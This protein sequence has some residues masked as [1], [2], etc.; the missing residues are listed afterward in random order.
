LS[1]IFFLKLTLFHKYKYYFNTMIFMQNIH[2]KLKHTL[3]DCNDVLQNCTVNT[4]NCTYNIIV[5][6]II[7]RI[8]LQVY[9][10]IQQQMR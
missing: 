2:T 5:I 9:I 4:N 3:L 8:L 1:Y 6:I 10:N 7:E